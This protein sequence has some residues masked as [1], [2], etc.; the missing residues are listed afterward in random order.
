MFSNSSSGLIFS[1]GDFWAETRR[2]THRLLKDF[3]YGKQSTLESLILE[4]LQDFCSELKSQSQNQN[5]V[6]ITPQF[7]NTIFLNVIWSL[8]TGTRF[9]H[10]DP[11]MK[12]ILHLGHKYAESVQVGGGIGGLFPKIIELAPGWTGFTKHHES[13]LQM[14]DFAEVSLLLSAAQVQAYAHV[15]SRHAN[16]HTDS[17]AFP[18]SFKGRNHVQVRSK[19][20]IIILFLGF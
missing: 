3:G 6:E 15:H 2:V 13:N 11:E 10:D 18:M 17:Y 12:R 1:R 5:V 20:N 14:L 19:C 8:M 16:M 7:F 9:K 4:E